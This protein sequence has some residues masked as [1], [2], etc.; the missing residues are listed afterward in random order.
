MRADVE[1][2]FDQTVR[3]LGQ[4]AANAWTATLLP[5]RLLH[6]T[7]RLGSFRRRRGRVVR[8]FGRPRQFLDL[9]FQHIDPRQQRQ[10]QRILIGRGEAAEI[11]R[12]VHMELES[13]RP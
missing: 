9:A 8:R 10:D 11:E 3:M 2:G 12:G 6:R 1:A 5:H 4:R 7:V 13:S